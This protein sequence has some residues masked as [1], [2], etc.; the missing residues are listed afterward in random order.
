[1]PMKS[2]FATAINCI[3]G[4][5][6]LPVAEFIR[7][8]YDVKYV[9]MITTPGPDKLLSEYKDTGEIEAVKNKVSISCNAHKSKLV[10]IAGHHD[11]A[12][13]PCAEE[14]HLKQIKKAVENV[15]GWGLDSE[16]YGIWVD[17]EG[18]VHLNGE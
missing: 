8:N 10:F 4:R 6:Q 2:K 3:D 16:V 17:K 18:K 13:N 7:K 1:M 15:K 5:V 14:N 12:G 11:C 9:D